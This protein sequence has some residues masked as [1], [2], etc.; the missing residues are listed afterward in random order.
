MRWS[1]E[2][3]LNR[4]NTN[5]DWPYLKQSNRN[6]A[7]CCLRRSGEGDACRYGVI[8]AGGGVATSPKWASRLR[9]NFFWGGA[10]ISDD[11]GRGNGQQGG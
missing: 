1:E 3:T 7:A 4:G 2:K 5:G 9:G 11:S 10:S 8:G 6:A